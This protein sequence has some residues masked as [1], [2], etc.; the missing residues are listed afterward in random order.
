MATDAR[1]ID[2]EALST[3]R[4]L[5]IAPHPDDEALGCGGLLARL[6]HRGGRVHVV[7]V[8]D[9]G[10]SHPRSQHWP[11]ARLAAQRELEAAE[12]LRR[13]GL[14][15][16]DRSFLRLSDAAMPPLET[17]DGATA[18]STLTAIVQSF[19]PDLVLLPWRRD[20]H[21]DHRD[22]WALTQAALKRTGLTP[23]QLEYAVWLDEFGE[24][25]DRPVP[26][27]A[28]RVGFDISDVTPIKRAAVAAHLSQTTDLINDDPA[29]F[30]LTAQTIDRLTG[31][32]E[33]YWRALR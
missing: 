15:A 4:V 14:A 26:G 19:E 30:R 28:E 17:P 29:A 27:E 18:L 6:A 7:F 24:P 3:R 5:V 21:C 2:I 9:G 31:P 13:L 33:H 11:R 25:D 12:A 16:Q 23:M 20:P 8:T 32:V 1:M 10:A 22:A